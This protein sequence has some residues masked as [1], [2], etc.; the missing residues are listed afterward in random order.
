MDTYNLSYTPGFEQQKR[1]SAHRSP[2][3]T[4]FVI[5]PACTRSSMALSTV[6]RENCSSLA[7]VP[8]DG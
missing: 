1:L 6:R 7:T 4:V 3:S 2:V 8:I 5:S